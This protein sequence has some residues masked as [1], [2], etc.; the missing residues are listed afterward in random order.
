MLDVPKI[1]DWNKKEKKWRG[2]FLRAQRHLRI[3]LF[4][5]SE[6]NCYNCYVDLC[7]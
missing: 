1:E 5:A 2:A 6:I 7:E 4:K 3:K